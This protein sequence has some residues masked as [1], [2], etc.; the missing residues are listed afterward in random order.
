[1]KLTSF[2]RGLFVA[3]VAI[4]PLVMLQG[5]GGGAKVT[6]VDPNTTIDLSGRWNDADSRLVSD[7]MIADLLGK[8]WLVQ[9]T[10]KKSKNPAI[11]CGSIR[12]KSMEH[13]AA[14][15]FVKDIERAMVNSGS[16]TVVAS[17]EAVSYTHLTLPT[18]REV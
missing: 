4:L 9:F 15:A 5:C 17:P 7:E 11:I 16:V 6:R 18:N 10:Q 1:M 8:P 3:T 12:N 2:R 13:I 14:G